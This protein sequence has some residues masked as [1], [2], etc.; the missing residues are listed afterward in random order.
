LAQSSNDVVGVKIPNQFYF[1]GQALRH[2]IFNPRSAEI[3]MV[4][5]GE[6]SYPCEDGFHRGLSVNG[7]VMRLQ[8]PYKHFN[9][10]TLGEWFLKT[11]QYTEHDSA[12]WLQTNR[13]HQSASTQKHLRLRT[14]SAYWVAF[15]F[16]IRHYFLKLGFLDGFRGLVATTYFMM[17]HLIL[18]VKIWE[19]ATLQTLKEEKDYLKPLE[20]PFR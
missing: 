10:N 9:V 18:Q 12:K 1:L 16:F 5:K 14:Y 4:K 6:W 20:T 7:K 13:S 15:R 2:G 3:R 19:K 8:N 11:N 17:Y